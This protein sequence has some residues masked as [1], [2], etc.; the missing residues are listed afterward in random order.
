[1]ALVLPRFYAII[2]RSVRPDLPL[3]HLAR[4]LLDAGVTLIQLRAKQVPTRHFLSDTEEL[5]SLLSRPTR[6]IVNDRPDVAWL[7][8]AAG[9]HL[10]QDDLPLTA[11][12]SLLGPSSIIGLS[13]H[14]LPQVEAADAAL[15]DYLAFGPVFST[16]TK[17]DAEPVVS[18]A[19]LR[20]VRARVQKPL[21]AIGGITP[22]N[23]AEAIE[24]GADAVAVIRGWMEAEDLPARLA[25]F[26][27]VLGRLS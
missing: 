1:M 24:A 21:V 16:A 14:T 11:A 20:E 25:E 12:R 9:V 19:R 22:A 13:T 5:L 8:G 4:T 17:A 18:P 15:A 26:R 27:R 2:D 7:A 10:G 23:A 3:G 6:L